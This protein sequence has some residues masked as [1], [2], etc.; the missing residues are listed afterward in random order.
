VNGVLLKP[1]PFPNADRLVSISHSAPGL[2]VDDI[3][4]A[5]F[6][7]CT[8][9]EQNR[10]FQDVALWNVAT[11]GVTGNGEPEQV[12]RLLATSGFLQVLGIEPVI[13]RRFF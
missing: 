8:E 13:G 10:V 4:S 11:A 7:Y 1:L 9:R 5:P 3:D 2:G 12:K 6:L